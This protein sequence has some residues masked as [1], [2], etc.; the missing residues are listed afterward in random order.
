MEKKIIKSNKKKATTSKATKSKKVAPV[1]KP[2]AKVSQ[3][4]KSPKTKLSVTPKKKA[5]K[6][7]QALVTAKQKINTT[8]KKIIAKIQAAP[9]K[10]K[11]TKTLNAAK[12]KITKTIKTDLPVIPEKKVIKTEDELI[13]LNDPKSRISEAVKSIKTNLQFAS[14]D[15]NVKTIM[16]TSSM[17]G[18]GKSFIAA[19]LASAF[20]NSDINVLLIDCDLRKGRQ[21]QIFDVSNVKGLSNLLIDDIKN[22]NKYIMKTKIDNIKVLPSGIVPPNPGELLGSKKNKDLMQKLRTEYDLIILDCPP[23]NGLADALVITSLADSVIIVCAQN[24]TKT[25]LLNEAKKALTQVNA[26]ITGVV[27]NKFDTK[28]TDSYYRYY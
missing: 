20:A 21:H 15:K 12:P 1:N 22:R 11:K 14:I 4:I 10:V 24:K 2:K 16:I 8:I 6:K 5:P 27:I 28:E 17:P 9:K 3:A 13:V 19:N 25:S 26:K 23:V 7:A 18:E